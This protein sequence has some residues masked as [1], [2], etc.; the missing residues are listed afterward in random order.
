MSAHWMDEVGAHSLSVEERTGQWTDWSTDPETKREG[1][2]W[3]VVDE[4]GQ[5]R[6][7]FG[8][9]VELA[10]RDE[11]VREAYRFGSKWDW[12]VVNRGTGKR[13][14]YPPEAPDKASEERS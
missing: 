3:T 5:Q 7:S 2:Y 10:T 13:E 12:A 6:G 4:E 9:P 14:P 11:A 8:F 1:T